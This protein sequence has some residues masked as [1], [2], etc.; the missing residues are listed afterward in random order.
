MTWC[1]MAQVHATPHPKTAGV[2][3]TKPA[4]MGKRAIDAPQ[5]I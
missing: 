3:Y 2:H 4:R 1:H 5:Q